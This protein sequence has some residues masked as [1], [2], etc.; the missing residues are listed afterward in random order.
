MNW[1]RTILDGIAMA[2]YFNLFAAVIVIINPRIMMCS[3]PKSIQ[4][5]APVPQTRQER[6]LYHLWMYFGMLLPLIIYGAISFAS[7]GV[8]DYW[9][10]FWMSYVEWLIISFSDFFVLDI[11]LLQKFKSRIQILGTEN[12]L[13]YQLKNWL[14]KLAIPEH[15]LGWP[16]VMAPL[17]SFIQA[18]LG[19]LCGQ[20]F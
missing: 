3:Y 18:A 15:F 7:C 6:K 9:T 19:L 1:S 4:N 14:K 16:F 5:D 17:V 8:C 2:A 10:L 12:H 13:D 11:Y 20:F